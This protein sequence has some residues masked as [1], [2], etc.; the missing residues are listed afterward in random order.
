MI[1]T[2]TMTNAEADEEKKDDDDNHDHIDNIEY[3]K[4]EDE[5]EK[6]V[7]RKKEASTRPSHL[8]LHH[9]QYLTLHASIILNEATKVI[10][11]EED[12][13]NYVNSNNYNR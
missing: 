1:K 8:N 9:H 5:N 6:E 11:Q 2:K 10:K 4:N 13:N 12:S 3:K 7:G